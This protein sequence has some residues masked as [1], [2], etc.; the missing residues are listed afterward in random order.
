MF[1]LLGINQANN[2]NGFKFFTRVINSSSSF[3]IKTKFGNTVKE[4]DKST[5]LIGR[6]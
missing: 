4:C 5:Y 6:N 1:I 3:T 2:F